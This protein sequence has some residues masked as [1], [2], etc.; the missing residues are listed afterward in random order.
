[1]LLLLLL[2]AR[3]SLAPLAA[4]LLQQSCWQRLVA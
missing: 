1:L 2:L 4:E 3:P